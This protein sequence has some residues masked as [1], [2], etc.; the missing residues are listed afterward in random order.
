[1][2]K[3]TFSLIGWSTVLYTVT[4]FVA[5]LLLSLFCDLETDEGYSSYVFASQAVFYAVII[6]FVVLMLRSLPRV[7]AAPKQS[8]RFGDF[9]VFFFISFAFLYLGALIGSAANEFLAVLVD[10]VPVNPVDDLSDSVPMWIMIILD[11]V[12]APIAE[13]L[14]FRKYILDVLR[15]FGD[16]KAI[17][18]CGF[19]FG[20]FHM[21]LDQFFYAA[22]L[23][24]LFSY[25]MI[26]TN[27]LWYTISLHSLVNLTGTLIVPKIYELFEDSGGNAETVITLCLYAIVLAGL[28]L[29]FIKRRRFIFDPPYFSFSAPVTF[30]TV[31]FN[32]GF[33]AM[34][35]VFVIESIITV[36]PAWLF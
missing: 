11:L 17:T 21:N 23:G 35:V 6:A 31:V 20:I 15:P 9:S 33:I 34:L 26:R 16:R 36:E 5:V 32:S 22:L 25:I 18:V 3:R 7:P 24:A 14:I 27:N 13:E 30:E 4:G 19:L 8:M 2:E 10:G 12:M 28:V 29:Y 1:M